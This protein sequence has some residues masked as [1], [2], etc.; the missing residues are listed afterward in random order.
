MKQKVV[1]MPEL[2]DY[3]R[4]FI[5]AANGGIQKKDYSIEILPGTQIT[6]NPKGDRVE[7][8]CDPP[9]QVG[10][11]VL[12]LFVVDVGIFGSDIQRDEIQVEVKGAR[13]VLVTM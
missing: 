12:G 6:I 1:H 8:K 9:I 10:A 7:L 11:T 3:V 2:K 13:D 5:E 4:D